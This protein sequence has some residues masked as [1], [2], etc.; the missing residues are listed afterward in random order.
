MVPGVLLI[1][2]AFCHR[3]K[4]APTMKITKV[5]ESSDTTTNITTT[6]APTQRWSGSAPSPQ[7]LLLP[8]SGRK[9][10]GRGNDSGAP[11][12]RHL[13]WTELAFEI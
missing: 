12:P 5:A 3:F 2:G 6:T 4:N 10:I 9:E 7:Q 8:L 13:I 1:I 11:P